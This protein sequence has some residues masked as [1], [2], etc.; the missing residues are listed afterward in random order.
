VTAPA[1][2]AFDHVQLALPPG[3]EARARAF[4]ADALGFQEV[5]K[6]AELAARGGAWF[7]SGSLQ[8]HLGVDP[9]FRPARKAHVALRCVRFAQVVGRLERAGATVTRAGAFEDGAEHAYVDDPFGNRIELIAEPALVA[10]EGFDHVDLRVSTLAA[11]RPFY[12]RLMPALGLSEVEEWETPVVEYCEPAR[13]GRARR[14]VGIHEDPAHR[15]NLSRVAF[16]V[17]SRAA[18][19]ALT[20]LIREA[21]GRAVEPPEDDYYAVFFND[22]DGNALEVCHRTPK[23]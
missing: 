14:L 23:E 11:A 15:P 2:A 3:E 18:V 16:G 21:G 6:P 17:P 9:D 4:Y 20:E 13:P 7:R 1:F 22:P 5:P 12:D 8:L 19:D 10:F